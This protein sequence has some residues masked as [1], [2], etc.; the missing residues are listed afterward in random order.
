[1]ES[2]AL[3]TLAAT[4]TGAGSPTA[5]ARGST[6]AY[7][8]PS[9]GSQGRPSG[10]AHHLA[11][12]SADRCRGRTS[13]AAEGFDE[14]S[15]DLVAVPVA[16]H[17]LG[18]HPGRQVTRFGIAPVGAGLERRSVSERKFH[19][20]MPLIRDRPPPRIGAW[21]VTSVSPL[22]SAVPP[23]RLPGATS[24]PGLLSA[25]VGRFRSARSGRRWWRARCPATP[26]GCR[27]THMPCRPP[28]R[29][30]RARAALRRAASGSLRA[31]P[32]RQGPQRLRAAR[33]LHRL[34]R[35]QRLHPLYR[36]AY[37][38]ASRSTTKT[39]VSPGRIAAPAPRSP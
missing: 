29:P 11:R 25:V 17:P 7:R 34:Q 26:K 13:G 15:A 33:L 9:C 30:V 20:V 23:S 6:S 1:M 12:R 38:T 16:G 27:P 4:R 39:R 36:L 28:Q 3:T 5:A 21:L 18:E 37:F 14:A 8:R 19:E 24:P 2:A 31:P 22:D 10:G 32:P 35:L